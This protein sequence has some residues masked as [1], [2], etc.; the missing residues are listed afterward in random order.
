MPN[1]E[2]QTLRFADIDSWP[3]IEAIDAMLEGQM[4]AIAAVRPQVDG[5]EGGA[6]THDLWIHN[7]AL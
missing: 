5:T 3:T 4:S 7:P 6:R 1:T 2:A